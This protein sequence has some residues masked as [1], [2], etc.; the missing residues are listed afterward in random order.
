MTEGQPVIKKISKIRPGMKIEWRGGT[1]VGDVLSKRVPHGKGEIKYAN[2]D[3][4]KGDWKLGSC[5]GF[6]ECIGKLGDSEFNYKGELRNDN[7][8][9]QGVYTWGNGDVYEGLWKNNKA[10]GKG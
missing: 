4:Y 7:F 9:G 3:I 5:H 1:Y 10:N 6:G 2:G 8:Y